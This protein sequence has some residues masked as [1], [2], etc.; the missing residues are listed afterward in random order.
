MFTDVLVVLALGAGASA[1]STAGSSP[2]PPA[3]AGSCLLG[4]PGNNSEQRCEAL[5]HSVKVIKR[6]ASRKTISALH[7]IKVDPMSP[8]CEEPVKIGATDDYTVDGAGPEKVVCCKTAQE[9]VAYLEEKTA[10]CGDG[11]AVPCWKSLE[12][13]LPNYLE[14]YKEQEAI[15]CSAGGKTAKKTEGSGS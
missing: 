2:P 12:K 7:V 9:K 5:L 11:P 14:Y 1:L 10:H 6:T 13:I 8:D 4:F 15:L 3:P